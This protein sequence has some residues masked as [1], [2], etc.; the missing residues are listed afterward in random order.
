LTFFELKSP[1]DMLAKANREYSRLCDSLDI[2]NV[3]NFFI[4]A[5][6]ISDYLKK[7]QAVNP[8]ILRRFLEN[9]NIKISRDVCDKGKHMRLTQRPDP[10][11]EI[12][13]PVIGT[14][15]LWILVHGRKSISIRMLAT[16][17]IDL[18]NDFF[19]RNGL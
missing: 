19:T 4:T 12:V 18:W 17:T 3:F 16:V 13:Q 8:L 15:D 10:Q 9:P 7:T 5:Y 11:T 14:G 6:H 1:Q 2:D